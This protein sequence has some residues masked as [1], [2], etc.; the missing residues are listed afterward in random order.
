[1]PHFTLGFSVQGAVVDAAVLVSS[2][3][4]QALTDAGQPIPVPQKIRG[5]IDT[6]AS[7]SAVDPS[8]LSALGL[9]PTGE[10]EIHT[11]STAG[12]PVKADTYDV[13]IAIFS[14]RPGDLHFIS[15]TVEVTS[16]QLKVQGFEVLIGRDILKS[17]ILYF[18]AADSLFTLSY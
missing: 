11:P 17:C 13:K 12:V 18:N 8:V 6:G 16:T 14:G 7:M 5:L 10:A 15:E 9:S 2:A 4:Q 1:M 3:K